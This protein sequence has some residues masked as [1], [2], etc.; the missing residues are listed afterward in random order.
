MSHTGY[1]FTSNK[2]SG[3]GITEAPQRLRVVVF[4]S[5]F[6]HDTCVDACNSCNIHTDVGSFKVRS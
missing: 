4:V 5:T 3:K 6:G 1:M 2:A